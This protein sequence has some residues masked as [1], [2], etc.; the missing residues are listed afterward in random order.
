M[1]TSYD[2]EPG[3]PV[4]DLGSVEGRSCQTR[5]LYVFPSGDRPTTDEAMVNAKNMHDGTRF[6]ADI[7]IDDE[8]EWKVGYSVKCIVVR[9][10][11]YR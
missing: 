8:T 5:V 6:I 10:T 4:A 3:D 2:G 1:T 7:S 11:A 9:A